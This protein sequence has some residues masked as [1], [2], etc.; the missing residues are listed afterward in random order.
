MQEYESGFYPCKTIQDEECPIG[1]VNSRNVSNHTFIKNGVEYPFKTLTLKKGMLLFRSF[2]TLDSIKESLI[3]FPI[4]GKHVI[5]PDHETYFFSH[6]FNVV[7]KYGK[8]TV[9]FELLRDVDVILG[10]NPSK[11]YAKWQLT[12][13]YG[14]ECS[15]KEYVSDAPPLYNECLSD[16][17]VSQ[18]PN[19]LGWIAPD[20]YETGVKHT[21]NENFE[22]YAKYV[23]FYE[24][25]KHYIARPEIALYPVKKRILYDI[26]VKPESANFGEIFDE[27][28][29]FNFK[30]IIIIENNTDFKKYKR[31]IDELLSSKGHTPK[32]SKETFKAKRNKTDG[33]YYLI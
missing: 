13:K 21:E 33:F 32:N 26:T 24:N 8:H 14:Q 20:F 25:S 10:M 16:A 12:Q 6:P 18:F 1:R 3:G 17:F 23:T 22:K 27:I 5:G 4:D 9:I 29:T 28:D 19:I 30:P 31:I 2:K 11:D 7:E 15:T